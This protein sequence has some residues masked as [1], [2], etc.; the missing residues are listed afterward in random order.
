MNPGR[1]ASLVRRASVAIAGLALLYLI[2]RFD[3]QNLPQDGCSPLHGVAPGAKLL[4]DRWAGAPRFGQS[5][6]FEGSGG[7]LH[8]GRVQPP[9]AE[10]EQAFAAQFDAG[11][12]WI[13]VDADDCPGLDSA[14]LGPIAVSAVRGPVVMVF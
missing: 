12:L 10:A 14:T 8:L 6:L 4:I 11:D 7:R 3:T 2:A 5:V 9:P 1:I 13:Q